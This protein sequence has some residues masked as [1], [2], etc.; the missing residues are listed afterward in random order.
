MDLL[1]DIVE[2]DTSDS[3][4]S[5]DNGTLSTNNCGTGFP[6]LYKPKKISS[7][8]ERLREKRAQKKQTSGKDAEK[9]QTST[10]A[11]LSEAKSIHNENIKVLQGMSDEQIVQ[12]RE[13]LYNS[14]DPKLIGKLLKN[15]NKRAKDENNTPLFAEIEGASG[16]W[17]G[18]NKQGIY[19]L[20]PLDDED[21]DVALEI[22]PKLGKDTKHVQFEEAGEEKDVEEEA[23]TNDDVDDIAPLDFQMAQCIDH[24]KNEE[25]FKDV[26]FIKE[27]SQNEINLEKLDINDPNFNDKLHEKY[28]PDLPKEVNKLKWMQPVQ[29][30]T[31][32][33]YIIEDVSECRFD[34][35]G[36]LVPPTRQIDSTIHSGLHHH[37]DSPE[38]AGYTIV[39]L[40]HLARSTFPSQRCIAIQTLGRIL[41]KLGQKSYY[42]LVP[43]IDADTYK[44][45]GSISNVMDKIYSMFWDLIKDGKVIESLEIASDEKFTRNLSVRNYAID[46][47]WL[48]KQ[49]GGDFRTKK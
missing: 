36:D 19:D 46:A 32:K 6:E 43:E 41:Y 14:L 22:R 39:E 42:Q 9:Q 3:V 38:L 21:V 49:G 17:V 40:E 26:H 23:K 10:D 1:G 35:N 33:N 11:P 8:K 13:D 16:T 18:G 2:K 25:L 24:M 45:D 5:N 28:F 44:K 48:W 15:I 7:W 37:S 47:L 31:D 4:E 20:P 29:Q 12:E 34:F 27:E 30:K